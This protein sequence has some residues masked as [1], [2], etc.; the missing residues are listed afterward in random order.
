MQFENCSKCNFEQ[1]SYSMFYNTIAS[2]QGQQV[3]SATAKLSIFLQS[4]LQ[5]SCLKWI[6]DQLS[7]SMSC[8]NI[9]NL[10]ITKGNMLLA[11]KVTTDIFKKTKPNNFWMLVPKTPRG[12]YHQPYQNCQL[13]SLSCKSATAKFSTRRPE[14]L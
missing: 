8:R 4:I 13:L 6:F 14:I 9:N 7:H 3:S 12:F 5:E 1:L 10:H 11:T 2:I